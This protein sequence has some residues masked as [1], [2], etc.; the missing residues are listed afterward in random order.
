MINWLYKFYFSFFHNV[1]F[2]KGVRIS[3]P[4]NLYSCHIDDYAYIGR[5]VEVQNDCYIGKRSRISTHS[6][7]AAGSVIGNDVFVAHGVMT[8]N[9]RNPK[10]NNPY[11]RHEP[12]TIQDES[13]V[14][15][16]SVLAP[17]VVIYKGGKLGCGAVLTKSLPNGETWVG[18]PARKLEK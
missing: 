14:G 5:F 8:T 12:I 3:F 11:Y 10:A 4:C 6:F 18:N 7:I 9:D 17:G 13:W 16:G 1:R 2:G 15:S